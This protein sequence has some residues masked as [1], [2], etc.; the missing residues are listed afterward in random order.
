MDKLEAAIAG[1]SDFLSRAA[2][3]DDS[4]YTYESVVN[5]EGKKQSVKVLDTKSISEMVTSIEKLRAMTAEPGK[6]SGLVVRVMMD[7]ETE[8][9]CR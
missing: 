3:D 5:D 8:Q 7:D 1:V 2:M 6:D 9:W 4:Y